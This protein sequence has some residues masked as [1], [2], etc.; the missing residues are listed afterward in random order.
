[1]TRELSPDVF[2]AL[3][4]VDTPTICNALELIEGRRKSTGFTRS[5]V[6]VADPHLPAMVGFA[7]TARIRADTPSSENPGIV[8]TRRLDYYRYLAAEVRPRFVVIEDHGGEP[9]IGAFW[10][11]VN[12]A[13][14][15][16]FGLQG[17]LTNGSIRD[18]GA[19]DPGFQ[20]LA[21]SIGPSHA[22]VHV[23][24][25]AT[26]VTV[27]GLALSPGDLI[28][29]DRHGAVVIEPGMEAELPRAI[30]VVTRKEA[31][32]LKAAR[33]ADF[34]IDRLLEAWGEAEDVH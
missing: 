20:L 2:A 17:V 8:R 23:T 32:I 21:G 18:L 25:F 10:G 31:P 11:E 12:V 4:A 15:K 9:G 6:I 27:F 33:Q 28:H 3:K 1:V 30:D 7:L 13:I 14:H 22:F 5:T 34:N 19:I 16:G 26:P 29:A 24:E